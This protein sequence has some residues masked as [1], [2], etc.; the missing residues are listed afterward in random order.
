MNKQPFIHVLF[1]AA[2]LC[3]FVEASGQIPWNRVDLS[4]SQ[5]KII[6]SK[7]PKTSVRFSVGFPV[8]DIPDAGTNMEAL[9]QAAFAPGIHE[10]LFEQLSGEFIIGNPSGQQ[11]HTVQ[12]PGKLN[13]M[14]G[15]QVGRRV[16]RRLDIHANAQYYKAEWSGTFPVTVFPQD[17]PAPNPLN[18]TI[19][20][21]TSGLIIELGTSLFITRGAVQ[22][23][24]KAGMRSLTPLDQDVSA[25]IHGIVFSPKTT[26][27]KQSFSP[28]G[29]AGL[30][31]RL[32]KRVFAD[33]EGAYGKMPGGRLATSLNAG[34]GWHLN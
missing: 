22:P 8:G 18:G 4:S 24:V 27:M 14:P 31:V 12:Q 30:Q 19:V 10:Q 33:I 21:S 29:G 20:T 1:G 28:Y 2:L 3:Q 34:I 26:Q 9:Q 23:Y 17:H 16:G 15:L 25:S 6:T 7:A 5:S 11:G 13:I 32:G